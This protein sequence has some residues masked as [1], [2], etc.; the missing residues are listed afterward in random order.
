MYVF[1]KWWILDLAAT[2]FML[3]LNW[4][5]KCK[6]RYLA[7]HFTSTFSSDILI[8]YIADISKVPWSFKAMF[9]PNWKKNYKISRLQL[10]I[11]IAWFW[12]S[13]GNELTALRHPHFSNQ[14]RSA[15]W[16]EINATSIRL[17]LSVLFFNL[18]QRSKLD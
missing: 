11:V 9:F 3:L 4:K 6:F 14:N 13:R 10:W 1:E 15:F 18:P 16:V 12:I 5:P 7:N 17:I 2:Q 8:F